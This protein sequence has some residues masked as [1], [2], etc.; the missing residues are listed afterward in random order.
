MSRLAVTRAGAQAVIRRR[1]TS[2][3]LRGAMGAAALAR[4]LMARY[5][6]AGTWPADAELQLLTPPAPTGAVPARADMARA[7]VPPRPLHIRLSANIRLIRQLMADRAARAARRR[8]EA[9]PPGAA[10]QP[11]RQAQPSRLSGPAIIRMP[12]PPS[13]GRALSTTVIRPIH[14]LAGSEIRT[15]LVVRSLSSAEPS[16]GAPAMAVRMAER[17]R[18]EAGRDGARPGRS[19]RGRR[20]GE[21]RPTAAPARPAVST[22]DAARP[23]PSDQLAGEP[24]RLEI[25]RRETAPRAQAG[26]FRTR[27]VPARLAAERPKLIVRSR[28]GQGPRL[29]RRT[30]AGRAAPSARQITPI[31]PRAVIQPTAAGEQTAATPVVARRTGQ[32]AAA[33]DSP[34]AIVVAQ[35]VASP[36]SA[37]TQTPASPIPA[38]RAPGAPRPMPPG[39]QR[40]Q[41]VTLDVRRAPVPVAQKAPAARE[42]AE[43]ASEPRSRQHTAEAKARPVRIDAGVLRKALNE[44]PIGEFEPLADRLIAEFEWQLKRGL[45]RN[46]RR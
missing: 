17:N 30:L 2:A 44:L 32:N 20:P 31:I 22:I 16:A 37:P 3:G 25:V 23:A 15:L 18:V 8:T 40:R 46:G 1:G 4:S 34:A 24:V 36:L 21:P 13:E 6:L 43:R 10:P 7:Q 42:T 19:E 33:P 11:Q 9:R 29:D 38:S 27:A 12:A 45:E 5:R 28:R 26:A 14:T 35:P 41:A 39:D